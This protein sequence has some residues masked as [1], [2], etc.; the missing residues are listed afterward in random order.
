MAWRSFDH[1]APPP[2]IRAAAAADGW[3]SWSSWINRSGLP[4]ASFVSQWTV[5][6]APATANGQTIYLFNG[7][8]DATGTHIVQPVLQWGPSPARGSIDAWGLSSFWV[9]GPDDPMFTT[10][11]TPV[12]AGTVVTG[13]M[14][15]EAQ[16]N[17]LFSC[18]SEF[19][20]YPT[21]QLTAENLPALVDCVL[22]LEAYKIGPGAPYPNVPITEFSGITFTPAAVPASRV[23]VKGPRGNKKGGGVGR[24]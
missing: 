14:T 11:W 10:H 1:S 13:R 15:V 8:Q 21:T 12:A 2:P 7:L 20:G 16:P 22:T 5:P 3:Q 23:G 24:A 17:G 19:D 18:T 9:G 6:V 4:I